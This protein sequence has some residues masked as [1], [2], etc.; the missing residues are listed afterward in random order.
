LELGKD[1]HYDQLGRVPRDHVDRRNQPW[2]DPVADETRETLLLL[3][4]IEQS[5]HALGAV[6]DSDDEQ[7]A[8]SIG[9]GDQRVQH[10]LA[11]TG[12]A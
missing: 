8:R 2:R 4:R 7:A 5:A 3:E 6:F 1:L 10:I 12:P 9:K 11:T